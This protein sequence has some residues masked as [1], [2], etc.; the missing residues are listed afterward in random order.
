[1]FDQRETYDL[2][3]LN[4]KEGR[5]CVH[6]LISNKSDY[7]DKT[8]YQGCCLLFMWYKLPEEAGAWGSRASR[9]SDGGEG[10]AVEEQVCEYLHAKF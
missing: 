7:S 3:C 6:N 1:M 2:R 5:D 8:D 9:V 10:R 4:R